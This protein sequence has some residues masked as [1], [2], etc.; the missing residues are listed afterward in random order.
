MGVVLLLSCFHVTNLDL[1]GHLT[2]GREILKT[3][4]IPDTEFFSHTAR[5]HPYPVHQWLGE[6]I[7]F[8]VDHLTG[9]PGLI[10]LRMG[11]ALL[12]AILLYRNARRE[13][14]PV[15]V[16]AGIV[17]LLIAAARP[18]LFI[19]P[20]LVS[21]VFLPLLQSWMLDLRQGRTRRLWPLLPLFAIWGHL[22]SGVLFGVLF[23]AGTLV[24]EGFKGL[25]ARRRRARVRAEGGSVGVDTRFPGPPVDGW[26]YRRLVLFSLIAVALPFATMALVNPSGVKPLVLPLLF[27][28]NRGFQ[29]MIAEYRTVDLSVDWPFDLVAGALLVGILLRPRRV[30]G[31]DLLI[32][33]GFGLIAF[34]AVRGI[35]PFAATAAPLLGR[36]WGSI[37]EDVLG[38]VGGS[39]GMPSA[40]KT[41]ADAVEAVLIL[42][43]IGVAGFLGARA[44]Q[45]WAIP[46]G[47][48][49][50]PKHYPERAL[51]F[52]AAQAIRGPIFNTD[53]W[54]SSILWRWHG[55]RLPVFVDARLEAYPEDFWRDSYYRVLTAAPGW[56]DVLARYGV[57]AALLRRAPGRSDDR[58]GEALWEDPGWGLVYWD[59]AVLVYL[60][61]DGPSARN[62]AVLADW[63][64]SDL[65]PRHPETVRDLDGPARERVAGQLERLVLWNPDSFLPRWVLAAAWTRLGRGEE[66]AGIFESLASRREARGN[67]A[68]LASRAEAELVA[69]RRDRWSSLLR[70]LGTDPG[71]PDALFGG[72]ALLGT[73]GK[74][75][76]AIEMYREV[77]DLRPTDSDAMN[78]LA[79][80]LALEES[81]R[82]EALGL[83]DAALERHPEDPY[84]I[85]SKGEVLYR[86]G[87]RGEALVEL[88]RALD[89]LPEGDAAARE[90]VMRW[91]LRAE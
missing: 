54:A 88:Q 71:H 4:A 86:S 80:L 27:F 62:R 15:V 5:G 63:G 57:Q 18:R 23:L 42:G 81:G 38:W 31:T 79:L 72:A 75:E 21:L 87:R 13:G 8:G 16:A 33:V 74:N 70:D 30:D 28:R 69:G 83:L 43:V 78:N 12:G 2:V 60:R 46:F 84:Y 65:N 1:G 91:M 20:F 6:V 14:A 7:L 34:Q 11:L 47:F 9:V 37:V 51:D 58:I 19:R 82:P 25:V 29:E 73:A 22:H 41:R 10:L 32:S 68:F 40:R 39:R 67:R 26:N 50:D 56:R 3:R 66:A 55:T 52:V 24:G 45:G 17:L 64:L 85:A 90:E 36:T 35:L 76:A 53:L 89:L 48:G 59:D 44:I 61:K 49:K 77:L